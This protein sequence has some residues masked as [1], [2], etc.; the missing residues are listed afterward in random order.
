M[1][2][3]GYIDIMLD[4]LDHNEIRTGTVLH[5]PTRRMNTGL[6]VKYLL[7]RYQIFF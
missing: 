7:I 1:N 5:Q 6:L 3:F 4:G 2:S